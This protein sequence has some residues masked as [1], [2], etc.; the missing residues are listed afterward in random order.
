MEKSEKQKWI[1]TDIFGRPLRFKIKKNKNKSRF[2]IT[3]KKK[4]PKRV[5]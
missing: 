2:T 1:V 4:Q 3:L 5:P